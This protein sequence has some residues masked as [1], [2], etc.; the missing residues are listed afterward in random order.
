MAADLTCPWCHEEL[1]EVD[2]PMRRETRH[3]R[4]QEALCPGPAK[5]HVVTLTLLIDDPGAVAHAVEV[6]RT[7]SGAMASQSGPVRQI[8]VGVDLSAD[9]EMVKSWRDGQ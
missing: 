6:L 8:I 1:V 4:G 5:P 3:H 7:L 2:N 9:G